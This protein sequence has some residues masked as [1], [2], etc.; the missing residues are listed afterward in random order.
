MCL[1]K[2]NTGN[3]DDVY[4]ISGNNMTRKQQ[5]DYW[6]GIEL[7]NEHDI[8]S[9]NDVV[10]CSITTDEDWDAE[11]HNGRT[12][13]IRHTFVQGYSAPV[14]FHSPQYEPEKINASDKRRTLYWNPNATTDANGH[15][16]ATFFNNSK[17]T[18]IVVSAEGLTTDG[19]IMVNK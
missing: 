1:Y 9:I 4:N 12:R 7:N 3:N 2:D 10:I 8:N 6:S 5:T 14:E 18:D 17:E 16:N 19:K 15:F 11:K 13:G